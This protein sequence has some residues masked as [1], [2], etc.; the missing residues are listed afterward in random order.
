MR[1]LLATL[2]LCAAIGCASEEEPDR[3]IDAEAQR[4]RDSVLGESTLP[5]ADAVRGALR[6]ADSAAARQE[7]LDSVGREP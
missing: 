3:A 5:G 2:L 1:V 6:V 7:R 4:A